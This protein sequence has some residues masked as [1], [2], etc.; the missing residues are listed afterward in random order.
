[1]GC[2]FPSN[3]FRKG[4]RSVSSVVSHGPNMGWQDGAAVAVVFLSLAAGTFYPRAMDE[5]RL[6]TAVEAAPVLL[7]VSAAVN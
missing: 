6:V 3:S 5:L 4:A 7:A 2:T 1:M